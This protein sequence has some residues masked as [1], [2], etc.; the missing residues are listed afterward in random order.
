M[1]KWL[2]FSALTA[3]IGAAPAFAQQ[4]EDGVWRVRGDNGEIVHVLP[5]PASAEAAEHR[6]GF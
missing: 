3:L 6:F 4:N 1:R 2:L 5:D